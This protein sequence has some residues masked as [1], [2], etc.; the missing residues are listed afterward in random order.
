MK[1]SKLKLNRR[2]RRRKATTLI[3]LMTTIVISIIPISAIGVLLIGGQ[4]S[5]NNTYNSVNSPI[6]SDSYKAAAVFER[7]ARKSQRGDCMLYSTVEVAQSS[8]ICGKAVELK[9]W[10]EEKVKQGRSRNAA[11]IISKRPEYAYI[12]LDETQLKVDYISDSHSSGKAPKGTVVIAEDVSNVVFS[13]TNINNLPQG[14][15]RMELTLTNDDGK[16][17][18]VVAAALMI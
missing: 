10:I 3:E 13:R 4:K 2:Q 16:S 17:V 1:L 6:E 14:C 8:Q 15:I 7:L 11:Y 18:T 5:W 12:Y 9:Y